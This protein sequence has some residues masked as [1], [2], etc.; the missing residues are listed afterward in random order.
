[1]TKIREQLGFL[2]HLAEMFN[3]YGA[4]WKHMSA[5]EF[6][7]VVTGSNE[8]R[9]RIHR[10]A[11]EQGYRAVDAGQCIQRRE[12]YRHL[13]SNHCLENINGTPLIQILGEYNIRFM[14]ALG[15]ARHNFAD[16][17]RLYNMIMCFGPYQVE[18]L[19]FCES[20][21]KLQ[22]GYPRYDEYFS[23]D[24][25]N[26]KIL[27]HYGCNPELQTIV[28]L[29]TWREL[30]SI[31]LYAE[32]I[33]L[34]TSAYN[35]IVKPHPLSVQTEHAR[36][37]RLQQ[38]PFTR[39]ITEHVDNLELFRIADF[40]VCDY[41]GP[42]FGALYLDK[43]VFLLNVPGAEDDALTGGDSADISLRQS[44]PNLDT[45]TIPK[46]WGLLEDEETW[47]QQQ[48]IRRQLRNYYFAPY[49]GFSAS[50]AA[51]ALGNREIIL[52]A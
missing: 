42:A 23:T 32:Q 4:V 40:M 34:L 12:R 52:A 9:E 27:T 48:L 29:P 1:M 8:E 37:E 24:H 33:S 14:Y 39:V 50:V 51:Q 43:K 21:V 46:I 35:V 44:L 6:E 5:D 49:Q 38:L 22:M 18:K 25:D 41:G 31:D 36:I 13:V 17:N 26:G 19:A 15:K 45:F 11:A 47:G 3:H 2:V 7:I 20:T 16:W 10:I 28:W 30:C